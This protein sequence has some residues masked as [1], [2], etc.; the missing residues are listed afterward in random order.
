M[1]KLLT[2]SSLLLFLGAISYTNSEAKVLPVIEGSE[3][4]DT[5]ASQSNDEINIP[6]LSAGVY[7]HFDFKHIIPYVDNY[8]LLKMNYNGKWACCHSKINIPFDSFLYLM[9]NNKNEFTR[10]IQFQ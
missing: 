1:K 10:Y 5:L 6:E 3:L 7:N 8:P 4:L 9:P 2:V